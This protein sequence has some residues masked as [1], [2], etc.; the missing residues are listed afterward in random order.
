MAFDFQ[1]GDAANQRTQ[2]N[3]SRA[4][5][6]LDED[7]PKPSYG[8]AAHPYG[9]GGAGPP[10]LG[11]AATDAGLS[12]F[13]MGG[14]GLRSNYTGSDFG[15]SEQDASSQIRGRSAGAMGRSGAGVGFN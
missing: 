10:R 14:G 8:A 12:A 5:N 3:L 13:G 4:L 1:R 9:A 6:L 15:D 2:D 7:N 11:T